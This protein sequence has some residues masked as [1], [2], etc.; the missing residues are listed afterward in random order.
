MAETSRLN[1]I[2]AALRGAASALSAPPERRWA[3]VGGLAVSARCE[4]RFT[5]DV[6]LAVSLSTDAEAETLVHSLIGTGYQVV[7]TVEHEAR[8]RLATV[9]LAAPDESAAGVVVDLL[10]ASSGIESE[11]AEGADAIEILPTL[12][13]PVARV[14]DLI[15][16]K[17]LSRDD[18]RRPQDAAD[19]RA[20]R[21]IADA[22][23]W[24]RALASVRLIVARGF[25]RGRPLEGE[26]EAL[27]T[28]G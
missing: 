16:L 22:G 21:A 17:L 20:L 6:D 4:P 7:A 5:R 18:E 25:D 28:G 26:L 3:L 13:A 12:I 24:A 2:E 27:R 11:V 23:E 15:A 9:R 10:F 14:G 19:L 8:R 1:R